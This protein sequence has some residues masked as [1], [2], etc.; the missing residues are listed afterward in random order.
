LERNVADFGGRYRMIRRLGAG[1]MGEVWLAHDQELYGRPV[2]IKTMHPHILA[3]AE[4]VARFQREMRLACQMQHP[5]IMTVFTSGNHNGVPFMV[6]EYLQGEDLAKAPPGHTADEVARIGRE[7]CTALAYAHG[8]EVVHR[9]IKPANLF[10]CDTGPV[11]VTDFGIAKAVGGTRLSATGTLIGTFPY[12]APEQWLGEPAA[13]GNDIWAVGCVL[14][15]LLSARLPRAYE[16]PVGYV[17]AAERREP[18]PALQSRGIPRW[19]ADAIMAMLQLDPGGRP[20]AAQC[21]QLLAGS[22]GTA[23]PG[24]VAA[25]LAARAKADYDADDQKSAAALADRK[26]RLLDDAERIARSITD[27][28]RQ[29]QALTGIASRVATADPGGAARLFADAER[30]VRSITDRGQVAPPPSRPSATEVLVEVARGMAAVD[31]DRAERIARSITSVYFKAEALVGVVRG[32]AAVDP[33]RAERIARSIEG[34]VSVFTLKWKQAE[35]LVGVASEVAA[36]DPDRAER[37]A[38]SITDQR[39]QAEAL[40]GVANRVAAENPR[41]ATRLFADAERIAQSIINSSEEYQA[42]ELL[43]EIA[44]GVAANDPDRAERIA[45]SITEEYCEAGALIGVANRVAAEDPGRAIRLFADAERIAQSIT[46]YAEEYG[47]HLLCEIAAEM[48]AL[49]PSRAERIA[50]SITEEYYE[51]GALIGVANRV[52][53][54]DPGRATRLFADAERVAQSIT[55]MP[56]R[57]GDIAAG[58]AALDPSRAERIAQSISDEMDRAIALTRVAMT[59]V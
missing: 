4:G 56:E 54:E 27:E 20:T 9:D 46:D 23:A 10:V 55:L 28:R 47:A 8:L 5:N 3:D 52:A 33:D 19:L 16:S 40:I 2:A 6:M 36:V 17:T 13:F 59:I 51:A 57:L 31:P 38:R 41:R 18:V 1:G 11:K 58:V 37:I 45:Q 21:V 15:E 30:T 34:R 26:A 50:Q 24:T 44:A 22:R 25:E 35:A 14:Y 7:T 49:D 32:M 48:A 43:G 53:A 29:A 39:R 12:M 42:M